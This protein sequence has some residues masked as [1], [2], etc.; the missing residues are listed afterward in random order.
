M[1]DWTPAKTDRFKDL[2]GDDRVIYLWVADGKVRPT[3]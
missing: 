2:Q 3:P 1:G